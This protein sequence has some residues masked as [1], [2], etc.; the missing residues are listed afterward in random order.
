MKETSTEQ[1]APF[2]ELSVGERRYGPFS[3]IHSR[4]AL[5]KDSVGCDGVRPLK[6]LS[7][8]TDFIRLILRKIS[9]LR[10]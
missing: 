8:K 4:A 5:P 2:R 1:G 10:W 7:L 3:E 6:R 9:K